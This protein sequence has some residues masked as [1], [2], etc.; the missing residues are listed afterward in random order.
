MTGK[1]KKISKSITFFL[2]SIFFLIGLLTFRD[3]GIWGDEEFQRF[4]GLYWLNYVLSF[5]SFDELK[6]IIAFKIDQIGDFTLGHPKY[7]PYYG[8]IF[9][10]PAAFLELIFQ[11][12]DSK[13]YFY[14]RHFLNFTFFFVGS[15][16]FYKLLLNRF[17]NYNV[18][19]IGTL[20]FVLSPRIL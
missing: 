14:L 17:S 10:L 20:F 4:N 11:I 15:I 9:D 16:F 1:D 2:F 12:E 5:T 19:L 13:N 6:N 18:A 8:V 7:Y 3:Y